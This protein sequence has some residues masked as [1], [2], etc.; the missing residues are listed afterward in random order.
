MKRK[1][2]AA[3]VALL[4]AGSVW[5]QTEQNGDFTDTVEYSKDKYKV[6]TNPFWSNWFISAGVGGQVFF[7][8][9]DRQASFGDRIAPAVDIAVGKW[10]NSM[11]SRE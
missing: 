8:D 1:V 2:F 3:A 10:F 5:A 4:A 7:G 6:E 11:G 9:H